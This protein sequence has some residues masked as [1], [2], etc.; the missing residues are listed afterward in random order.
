MRGTE[1][2]IIA[3]SMGYFNAMEEII[4]RHRFE[5]GETREEVAKFMTTPFAKSVFSMIWPEEP[6]K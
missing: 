4:V 6:K 3:T 2:K 1:K 5:L